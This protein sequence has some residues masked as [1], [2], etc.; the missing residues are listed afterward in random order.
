M[1]ATMPIF[2]NDCCMELNDILSAMGMRNAFDPFAADFT[3]L[4]TVTKPDGG[5]VCISR[6]LHK[7]H[8]E[9]NEAGTRAAAV[10]EV[11]IYCGTVMTTPINVYL[12]RPFLYAIVDM[13]TGTPLFLGTCENPQIS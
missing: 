10:T 11:D 13:T 5:K 9:V 1:I 7:T 3:R 12:N 2:E 8:I 6:V 4:G